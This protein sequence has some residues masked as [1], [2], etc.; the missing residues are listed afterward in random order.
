MK[1]HDKIDYSGDPETDME[2]WKNATICLPKR[3]HEGIDGSDIF[4][5]KLSCLK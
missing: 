3:K 4:E 5:I 1:K 2:F